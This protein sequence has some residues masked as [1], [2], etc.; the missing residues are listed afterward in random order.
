MHRFKL[1]AAILPVIILLATIVL[2]ATGL[3]SRNDIQYYVPW[4]VAKLF[5]PSAHVFAEYDSPLK[6][7]HWIY[8]TGITDANGDG[9][10]DIFTSN[11]NWRQLLLLADDQGGYSDVGKLTCNIPVLQGGI[12]I[13]AKFTGPLHIYIHLRIHVS[14]GQIN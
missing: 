8:D 7:S 2:F 13:H 14:E 4:P 5:Y 10:L 3:L 9:L 1:L 12:A 11:H 6:E